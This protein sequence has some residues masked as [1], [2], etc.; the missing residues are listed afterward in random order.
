MR[1]SCIPTGVMIAKCLFT[2]QE[3]LCRGHKG[4]W[5]QVQCV[6]PDAQFPEEVYQSVCLLFPLRQLL[7][8]CAPRSASGVPHAAQILIMAVPEIMS[9][10]D[11]DLSRVD[12][13]TQI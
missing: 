2:E 13:L 7:R 10:N 3:L 6:F 4:K 12:I 8:G 1:V 9:G 5:R 11:L